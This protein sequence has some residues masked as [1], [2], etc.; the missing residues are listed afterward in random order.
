MVHLVRSWPRLWPVAVVLIPLALLWPALLNGQP[1][2][3]PDTVGYTQGAAIAVERLFGIETPWSAQTAANTPSETPADATAADPAPGRA[4]LGRSIYYGAMLFV[5][6]LAGHFWLIALVQGALVAGTIF[7]TI[8]RLFPA[9]MVPFLL[10]IMVLSV[11]TPLAFFVGLAMPDIFAGLAIL[12]LANL[13]VFTGR[14]DH[15]EWACWAGLLALATLVHVSHALIA[16]CILA[17]VL[18]WRVIRREQAPWRGAITALIALVIAFVGEFIFVQALQWQSGKTPLRPPFLTAR[19]IEDGPGARLLEA[20]CP[21]SGFAACMVADRLPITF[22]D[23]LWT[24]DPARGAF[25]AAPDAVRQALSEEQ[26]A[27]AL[28]TLAHD[29]AGTLASATRNFAMQV[30]LFGLEDF[31]YSAQRRS[32]YDTALPPVRQP[33]LQN[34]AAY[35]G[36]AAPRIMEDLS[37]LTALAA[38]LMIAAAAVTMR[39]PPRRL[40]DM[41]AIVLLGLAANAAICGILSGPLD[42]FQGR[43]IW[44]VPFLA[45]LFALSVRR[46]LVL[47]PQPARPVTPDA[48][49]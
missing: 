2:H 27:F 39:K 43:V 18:A 8:R 40:L 10:S 34:S 5:A 31:N 35:H 25:D 33:A 9:P 23:F 37:R 41:A 14:M 12:A 1:F 26:T 44:L 20:T 42:R 13:L 15:W 48:T 3:Y 46:T 4:L 7:L 45:V 21:E 32:Y 47:A 38:V 28:A 29:P 36:W 24:E 19:L 16:L 22:E 11:T 30:V 49:S 17:V 6:D